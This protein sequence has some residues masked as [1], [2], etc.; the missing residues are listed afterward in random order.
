[1]H[2]ALVNVLFE[3]AMKGDIVPNLF[4][5]KTRFGYRE[6]DQPQDQQP[7]IIINL[8]GAAAS[9]DDWAKAITVAPGPVPL[10]SNADSDN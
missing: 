8:P 2:D 6:G 9:L 3:R 7:R 10:L 1:M 5:L 4:L